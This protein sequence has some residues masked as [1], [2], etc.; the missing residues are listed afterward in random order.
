MLGFW[1]LSLVFCY[2]WRAFYVV[3]ANTTL[4]IISWFLQ[5]FLAV[6][7][8]IHGLISAQNKHYPYLKSR[9]C[10]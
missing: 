9:Y 10:G 3:G 2:F 5:H 6:L 1:S 8:V 7:E 4:M